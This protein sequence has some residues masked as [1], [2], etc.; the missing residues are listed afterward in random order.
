MTSSLAA[1]SAMRRLEL[2]VPPLLL[3]VVLALCMLAIDYAMPSFS[4]HFT[5]KTWVGL[6]FVAG[7]VAAALAGV[8]AFRQARTTVDPRNPD[9]S[10]RIVDQGIYGW[11]RNPMYLGFALSLLGVA[12]VVGNW[13]AVLLAVLFVPYMNL[14]QIRPEERILAG[15]FGDDYRSYAA[16]VRRWI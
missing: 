4:Y 1:H 12:I 8:N 6:A 15:K 13:M 2:A 11:T 3:M 7:G 5:G 16:R 9:Q 10:S 14:F